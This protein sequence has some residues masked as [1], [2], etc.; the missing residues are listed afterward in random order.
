[1]LIV[2]GLGVRKV[3]MDFIAVYHLHVCVSYEMGGRVGVNGTH[4]TNQE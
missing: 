4:W 1:M 2:K 3:R